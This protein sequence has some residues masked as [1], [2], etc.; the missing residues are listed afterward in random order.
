MIA[1]CRYPAIAAIAWSLR[2]LGRCKSYGSDHWWS[3]CSDRFGLDGRFEECWI[4]FLPFTRLLLMQI[5]GKSITPATDERG[6]VVTGVVEIG[7]D[8]FGFL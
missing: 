6:V 7:F 8:S 3:D 1:D 5:L 2:T 4:F